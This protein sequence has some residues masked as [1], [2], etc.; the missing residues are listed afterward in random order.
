MTH[1]TLRSEFESLVDPY[2]PVAQVGTGFDFTEGPVWHPLDQFLLFSDMPA[3]VRRRWDARRGVVEVRRP[4]NKCN[5]MSYD[6]ELN[7]IVCEHATSSLIRE[8][9]DGRREIIA[10]HFEN[11]ELNSPNDVCVHSSGA[12][13]FSDPWYGRMPV[14]GVERPRQL[15]FQGVYRVPPTGGPPTLLVDRNLFDQPNGL[16]FSPDEKRLYVNDT[17][18]TLIR[19]F[20]VEPDGS[21]SNS[22]IFASN[23]R[24]EL[25]AGVPDGMKCDQRGNVWVTAPGGVWVYS[26]S[27]DLLGK[28]RV[29]EL[30]ANLAWGGADFRTLYLTATHSIYAIP[31]KVGPRHEPYMSAQRGNL[32]SASRAASQATTAPRLSGTEMQFDS[33]RCAMIIQDLQND[34]IMEGGALAESGAPAHARQQRVVDNVRRLAEAA[35]TRGVVII[36]VWFIVEPGAP[37]VTLNAPLFEGLVDSKAMVRGGWG[38]APVAGLEPKGGDF[39]VEKMRMSAWEGTRLETILK[40]TGRDIII[41]TG[42]WTNM[43]VEH[44]ARTGADK[45]YFMVVPE[46]C[47]ST[48]NAEWH[49]AAI[50]FALQNVSI[51]T[52]ADAVIKALG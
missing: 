16:C 17:V 39:V 29:P 46:D 44:T 52:N 7:L 40:A 41:N 3:D 38:A 14:Y 48:M 11:Q 5:G 22:R 13:Y 18:Q 24:S 49:N 30:V 28:V 50:N 27:G 36:H 9:S 8:R 10:S 43:S 19:A 45:G 26:P 1:M 20:D 47:C 12:V 34:V 23:I 6:A 32:S 42:A 2:A 35:R 4:S 51:V 37:G 25:E 21:L 31:T 15:G 33:R